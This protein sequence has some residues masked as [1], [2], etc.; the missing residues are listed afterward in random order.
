MRKTSWKKRHQ[1]STKWLGTAKMATGGGV[2]VRVAGDSGREGTMPGDQLVLRGVEA[3][4][5]V[6]GCLEGEPNCKGP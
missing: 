6:R 2:R 3:W 4:E 1:R 5:K